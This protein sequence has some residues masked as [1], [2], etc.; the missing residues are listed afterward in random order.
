M[1]ILAIDAS[2]KSTGIALFED[3]ELKHYDCWT[4]SSNDL[5]KRISAI[6]DKLDNYLNSFEVDKIVLEEVRPEDKGQQANIKTHKAL[7]YLQAAIVFLIHERHP[8]ID[9]EYVYPSEWRKVCGIQ[10][11][12]GIR[13]ESLKPKDIAFVKSAYGINVN[14][15]IADAI[16]IGHAYAHEL[17]NKI[18]W[19]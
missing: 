3:L 12:R 14:D 6:I 5:V 18:E 11:G 4:A 16:G 8:S 17:D 1:R 15:D 10:T 19:E 9:I 2:T 13:R 7:M